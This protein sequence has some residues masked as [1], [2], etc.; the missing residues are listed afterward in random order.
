MGTL[1]PGSPTETQSDSWPLLMQLNIYN[2]SQFNNKMS[3]VAPV[4]HFQITYEFSYLK[5]FGAFYRP[6]SLSSSPRL[7][8]YSRAIL[9]HPLT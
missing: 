9:S 2:R 4:S 3:V 6:L 1:K 5:A 7:V 8:F